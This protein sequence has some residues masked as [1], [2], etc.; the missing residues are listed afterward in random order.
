MKRTI[1]IAVSLILC[2][3][4]VFNICSIPE[5]EAMEFLGAEWLLSGFLSMMGMYT[6]TD[7][8]QNTLRAATLSLEGVQDALDW[9]L[10]GGVVEYLTDDEPTFHVTNNDENIG[11]LKKLFNIINTAYGG[12]MFDYDEETGEGVIDDPTL[13]D[14]AWNEYYGDIN[15]ELY[16][17]IYIP[18]T[19]GKIFPV[20]NLGVFT[21]SSAFNAYAD[22]VVVSVGELRYKFFGFDVSF[23]DVFGNVLRINGS[24]ADHYDKNW[25]GTTYLYYR[26]NGVIK[27]YVFQY[28]SPTYSNERVRGV[29]FDVYTY[30]INDEN[31]LY[32]KRLIPDAS[33][34]YTSNTLATGGTSIAVNSISG[35]YAIPTI[36][37]TY[38]KTVDAATLDKALDLIAADASIGEIV[39]SYPTTV[40]GSVDW[41]TV[42]ADPAAYYPQAITDAIATVQAGTIPGTDTDD[43]VV[44]GTDY[45]DVLGRIETN[46]ADTAKAVEGVSADVVSGI[47]SI[48]IPS[49]TW[50][51]DT[52]T[53]WVDYF[54]SVMPY[55]DYVR[56]LDTMGSIKAGNLKNI[57]V[58]TNGPYLAHGNDITIVDWDKVKEYQSTIN[59]WIYGIFYF[60]LV[61]FNIDQI[62]RVFK[63]IPYFNPTRREE[64]GGGFEVSSE[65]T[66][67]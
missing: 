47:E 50:V 8:A 51:E 27:V 21:S 1:V 24:S 42:A 14:D 11:M 29:M 22:S 40:D 52:T 13:M 62:H 15:T 39:F 61:F 25:S 46:T 16:D 57:T 31:Y 2:L 60:L 33:G 43:P 7:V 32:V 26:L 12:G 37:Y 59:G 19:D 34:E 6:Q 23:N 41:E 17:Y 18:T 4:M 5:A 67:K 55:D 3:V 28:T 65:R 63:G 36:S 66:V 45:S 53:E 38:R 56:M 9:L 30:K 64:K 58:S 49:E 35:N 44:I 48:F 54:Q 10:E 20:K